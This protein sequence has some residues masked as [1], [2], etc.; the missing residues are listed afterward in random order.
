MR[1]VRVSDS[2]GHV[3]TLRPGD[4]LVLLCRAAVQFDHVAGT[5]SERSLLCFAVFL[6]M[7]QSASRLAVPYS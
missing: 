4:I 6:L 5:T 1:T 7:L 2:Q 3:R